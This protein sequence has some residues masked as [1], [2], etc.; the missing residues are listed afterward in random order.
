MPLPVIAGPASVTICDDAPPQ[1]FEVE[2]PKLN[3]TYLW[4]NGQ[5]GTS[6]STLIFGFHTV[7]VTNFCGTATSLPV[8]LIIED[9]SP[10]A[11]DLNGDN[12]INFADLS[13]L[14]SLMGTSC[15]TQTCPGDLNSDQIVN[16]SDLSILLS[17]YGGSCL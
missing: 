2:E 5:T 15:P 3:A 14:L 13:I 12:F 17:N 11:G 6:M 9:C 4:S 16:F 1:V 8:E 10:C 7:Q